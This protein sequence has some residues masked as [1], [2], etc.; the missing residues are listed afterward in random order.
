MGKAT[1]GSLLHFN[2]VPGNELDLDI[3]NKDHPVML[4][5]CNAPELQND[6][7]PSIGANIKVCKGQMKKPGKHK[8]IFLFDEMPTVNIDGGLWRC[9]SYYSGWKDLYF[10]CFTYWIGGYCSSCGHLR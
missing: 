10:L 6:L 9:I 3:I 1:P 2:P 7:A 8:S 4:C 5:V